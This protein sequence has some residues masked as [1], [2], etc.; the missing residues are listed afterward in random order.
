MSVMMVAESWWWAWGKG[1]REDGRREGEE[2]E[3]ER[4]RDEEGRR[5]REEVRGREERYEGRRVRGPPPLHL[6]DD[7]M[8]GMVH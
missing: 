8:F 1:W 2:G 4:G 5:E 7:G 3:G 6:L